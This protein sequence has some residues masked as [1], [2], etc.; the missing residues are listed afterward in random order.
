MIV[1]ALLVHQA[2][3]LFFLFLLQASRNSLSCKAC[4]VPLP[5]DPVAVKR[6]AEGHLTELGLCRLCGASFPDRA[7]AVAHSL[8][9]VG[10]RLFACEMCRQEF[11]SRG[12]LLRHHHRTA[13]AYS[14]PQGALIS[15]SSQGLGSELR[16]AVCT[17]TLSKDFQVKGASVDRWIQGRKA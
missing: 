11:C 3:N 13:S 14:I 5:A 9:H 2:D 10:V 6:H 17:K 7:A 1:L 4:S 12:K 8:S 15:G 16:C